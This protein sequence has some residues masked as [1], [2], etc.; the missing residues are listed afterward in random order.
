MPRRPMPDPPPDPDD[1]PSVEAWRKSM[2][3]QSTERTD[4]TNE[5]TFLA[6]VRTS[7]ALI[8]LGFLV[9]RFQLVLAAPAGGQPLPRLVAWVPILFFVL[10]G[11]IIALGAW[12]YFRVR[13]EIR[14]E[15]P[16]GSRLIRDGLMAATLIFLLGVCAIFLLTA[17]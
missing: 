10:G 17:P 15:R 3:F 5:R 7:L 12:E 2:L 14:R 4:L 1:P 9:E 11:G 13:R 16:V 6:W 8:A